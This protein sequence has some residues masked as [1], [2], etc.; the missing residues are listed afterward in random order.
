MTQL[1]RMSATA[2]NKQVIIFVISETI[3]CKFIIF[4]G[5]A[6][7]IDGAAAVQSHKTTESK[8]FGEYAR[9]EFLRS[10]LKCFKYLSTTRIELFLIDTFLSV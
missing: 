1:L 8:T 2:Q 10:I 3:W 4:P 6:M 5:T 9:N 7:V